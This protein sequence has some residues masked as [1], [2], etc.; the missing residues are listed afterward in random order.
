MIIFQCNKSQYF[1]F[2]FFKLDDVL[3]S[4]DIKVVGKWRKYFQLKCEFYKVY[5]SIYILIYFLRCIILDFKMI[6]NY[7]K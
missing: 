6:Y 5:V 3:Q 1:D 4:F 7:C 2:C